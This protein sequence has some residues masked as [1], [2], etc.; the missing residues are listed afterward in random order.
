MKVLNKKSTPMIAM[1]A[2]AVV[3]TGVGTLVSATYAAA[4]CFT[5]IALPMG[6]ATLSAIGAYEEEKTLRAMG[7]GVSL[8]AGAGTLLLPTIP[9][10]TLLV[11]GALTGSCMIG[12]GVTAAWVA[13]KA[14]DDRTLSEQFEKDYDIVI[15]SAAKT[16]HK[17]RN[18]PIV[19]NQTT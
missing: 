12:G 14:V 1:M 8:G 11:T 5:P 2:G 6:L 19:R 4:M 13:A 3:G 7:V 9:L 15:E 18:K 10:I 16:I 17:M